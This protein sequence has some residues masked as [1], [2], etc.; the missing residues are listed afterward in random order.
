MISIVYLA[1]FV[2]SVYLVVKDKDF[3]TV[4]QP[5]A[6]CMQR[7]L[8]ILSLG[9]LFT[10]AVAFTFFAPHKVWVISGVMTLSISGFLFGIFCA[11]ERKKSTLALLQMAYVVVIT[12]HF[13]SWW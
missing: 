1:I 7:S 11:L 12:K 8:V 13:Y 5:C 2:A 3:E 10:G 4:Q 6:V 9:C